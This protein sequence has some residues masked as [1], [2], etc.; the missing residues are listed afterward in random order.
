RTA[1]DRET[2]VLSHFPLHGASLGSTETASAAPP[3]AKIADESIEVA[4]GLMARAP[5]HGILILSS[6]ICAHLLVSQQK[7]PRVAYDAKESVVKIEVH[8]TRV[9]DSE[10]VSDQ[11]RRCFE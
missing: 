1:P 10:R 8:L 5:Q 11:L 9:H 6:F 4:G 2:M 3:A 7:L